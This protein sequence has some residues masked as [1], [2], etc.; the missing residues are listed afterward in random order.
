MEN[1]NRLL[2]MDT[3]R[4]LSILLVVMLHNAY[5]LAGGASHIGTVSDFIN[6]NVIPMRMEIMFF[7]SGIFVNHSLQKGKKAYLT[8]KLKN[9]LYPFLIWVAIYGALRII[10]SGMVNN[11]ASPLSVIY[12]QLT[13]GGDITWFLWTLMAFFLL[14][15]PLRKVNVIVVLALCIAA[16]YLLPLREEDLYSGYNPYHLRY[17]AYYFLF[18]YLG[19]FMS[20]KN[21]N[22]IG[23]LENRLIVF[24]AFSAWGILMLTVYFKHHDNILMIPLTLLSIVAL[25][26]MT[27][28][29]NNRAINFIGQNSIVFYLTHY[30]IIQFSSKMIKVDQDNALLGDIKYL[31]TLGLA[32]GIPYIIARYRNAFSLLSLPY[33]YPKRPKQQTG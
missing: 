18:F 15:I 8:G 28:Y 31:I 14:V 10:F 6:T 17:A 9:I 21:F 19:D 2:W 16:Y 12:T 23:S 11:P 32:L 13:G 27:K 25:I 30:L 24:L 1:N 26:Y 4:G 33:A 7:L 5:S 3:L 22:I 29:I 20:R